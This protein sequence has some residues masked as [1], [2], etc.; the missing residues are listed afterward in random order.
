MTSTAPSLRIDDGEAV[1]EVPVEALRG[2][3]SVLPSDTGAGWDHA[4]VPVRA[5]LATDAAW[6]VVSSADGS[7]RACIP[8]QDLLAGGHLLVGTE[9][10]PMTAEDGGPVRLIVADGT[11]L[12]WNVKDVASLEASAVRVPDSVP[13]NPPH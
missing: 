4:A 9:D 5:V 2:H 13:E 3:R 11:T 8:T 12:C 1:T 7:Y 10:D 6:V